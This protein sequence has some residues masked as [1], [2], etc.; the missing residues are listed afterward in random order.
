[1]RWCLFLAVFLGRSPHVFFFVC[2]VE[3]KESQKRNKWCSNPVV[4]SRRSVMNEQT[5]GSHQHDGS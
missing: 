1:M 2:V 4:V 3:P 5:Q